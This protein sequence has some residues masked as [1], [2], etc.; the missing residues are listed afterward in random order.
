MLRK[1]ANLEFLGIHFHIGSQITDMEV[2]KNLCTRI[3]EMQDWF[4]NH[5]FAIKILNTGGG[6]GVDY[7]NPDTN[8]IADFET[9]LRYS[10]NS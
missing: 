9:I 5:G 7:Y 8:G 4:E 3:N 1:C 6:L 2:Y 10:V